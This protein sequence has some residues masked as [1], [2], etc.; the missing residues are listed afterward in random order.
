MKLSDWSSRIEG[1]PDRAICVTVIPGRG[2]RNTVSL[3]HRKA[4]NKGDFKKTPQNFI[5]P[6]NQRSLPDYQNTR[7]REKG[8]INTYICMRKGNAEEA[9][10]AGPNYESPN[11][12]I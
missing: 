2:K 6:L 3:A 7:Q 5:P 8:S 12:G 11:S 10:D 1:A 4:L 9:G